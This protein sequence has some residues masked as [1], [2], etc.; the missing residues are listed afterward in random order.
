[1]AQDTSIEAARARIQRLVEEI[2]AL[3][4]SE[5]RSEEF[6]QQFLER[7]VQATDARG[8]AVWLVAPRPSDGKSE[9][10]I[11]AQVEMDSSGFRS[12]EG[13]HA[14][15][16]RQLTEVAQTKKPSVAPP[17]AAAPEPGSLQAQMA[18]LQ[19]AP[20]APAV[21]NRTPYPFF[22]LPLVLKDQVLGVLQVWLQPYVVPANYQEFLTFLTSLAAHVEQHLHS[23]RLGTLALEN[24]RLQQVLKFTSDLAGSLDPLEV[25]RLAAN[26]GRDLI[27]CERCSVLSL[28]GDR[29][30]VV[31]I[32]GQ[33]VVEKKSSMVKAMVAF[34]GA[35]AQPEA[36]RKPRARSARR[37]CRRGTS[38]WC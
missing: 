19:G 27:G 38:C 5:M 29:W 34:I 1:M 4:R 8:G 25:A 30:R 33:E 13:Q 24:Q 31:A 11:V 21:A 23:R 3:S 26:Y 18:Q 12:D 32:S 35:H 36:F 6:F 10:Q 14:F 17:E 20:A 15:L 9:F 2:A 37:G 7:A 22:H 16:L 28:R